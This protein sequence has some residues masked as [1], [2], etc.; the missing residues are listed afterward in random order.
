LIRPGFGIA[1]A[2]AVLAS[3]LLAAAQRSAAATSAAAGRQPSIVIVT[4]GK[5]S[6][7]KFRV[8]TMSVK[9]GTVIFK[10]TN[11]GKLRHR[12]GINGRVSKMLRS[13][14]STTLTVVFKKP[15]RYIYSDACIEDPNQQE[16]G[17]APCA[18]GILKVT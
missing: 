10:I 12:F 11:L 15:S 8:S 14:Q 17:R 4:A 6:E 2:T 1:V 16:A 3:S 13:H 5:P 7:H 9:R 18:G